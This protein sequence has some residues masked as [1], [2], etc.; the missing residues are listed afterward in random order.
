MTDERFAEL[1]KRRAGR[2]I[3]QVD[4]W[5]RQW[6]TALEET[7]TAMELTPAQIARAK[8]EEVSSVLGLRRIEKNTK[9]D[10]TDK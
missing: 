1:G 7:A 8:A 4:F 9:A 3:K 6:E 5:R 2:G 10:G